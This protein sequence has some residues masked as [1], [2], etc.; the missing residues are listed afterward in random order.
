MT[1]EEKQDKV[2]EEQPANNKKASVDLD[3]DAEPNS[4]CVPSQTF[5]FNRFEYH[6][7]CR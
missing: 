3:L 6:V 2:A 5:K 7:N 4:E 1:T